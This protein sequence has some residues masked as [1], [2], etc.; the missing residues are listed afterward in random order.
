VGLYTVPYLEAGDYTV[1]VTKTGFEKYTE[2]NLHLDPAQTVKIDVKLT[3]GAAS[4]QV[5]VSASTLQINTQDATL[6]GLTTA[7]VI[8]EIPN[9][10]NNPFQYA[11][12]QNGVVPGSGTQSTTS[13][14]GSFGVGVNGRATFADFQIN[15]AQQGENNIMIDG[16]PTM[17]GGYNDPTVIPNLEGI[18]SVQILANAYSSEYGR[19]AGQMSITTKSGSNKFHGLA[20]YENRNEALMANTDSNKLNLILTPTNPAYRRAAFKVNDVGGEIDGPILKNRLFFTGSLHYL[21]HN[22]GTGESLHVP[23]LLERTGDW[24]STYVAGSNGQPTPVYLFNPSSVTPVSGATNVYQRPEFPHSSNCNNL[25]ADTTSSGNPGSPAGAQG[26][27]C[28]DMIPSPNP[29]GLYI[30]SL[31]P[32]P[33]AG[34]F[35]GPNTGNDPYEDNN[36]TDTIVNTLSQYTNE[37]RVDY[38]RGRHSIYGSGGIQWD[39]LVN[40]NPLGP[41]VV[42]GINDI[43]LVT[44]DRNYFVQIGDTV[45]FSPTL[46]V[47]ARYGFTRDHTASLGGNVSGFSNYSALGVSAA[48]QAIMIEPGAVPY[49]TPGNPW[50]SLTNYS[51]FNNKQEHQINHSGNASLTK[52]KGNWTFKAGGQFQIILENFNDFE[53]AAA[54]LG[55]CCANDPGGANGADNYSFQYTNAT[56][57][58]VGGTPYDV[59]PQQ[60]GAAGTLT[61]LGQGEWF[62]RPGANLRPAYAAKYFAFY[63]QNDWKVNRKLTLN[64]GARWE[65]QPGI[66][67]RYNRLAGY[68]FSKPNPLDAGVTGIVDF[69][70]TQ[71]YSRNLYDTE[72]NN[73]TPHVGFAYQVMQNLVA[74][75][76]FSINYLPDNTGYY[77]SPNDL[78]ESTWTSGN[79]GAQTYGA[80]PDGVPVEH[81]TD[82]APAVL[83]TGSNPLAPQTYGVGEAYFPRNYQNAYQDQFNFTIETSF[84]SKSQWLFSTG[85]A[86]T[87]QSHLFTRNLNFENIQSVSASAPGTLAAWRATLISTNGGTN[88]QTVQVA[89]PYQPT[90]GPLLPLQGSLAAA[91]VQ[92]YIPYLP[93]PL[94]YGGQQDG[95]LGFGSY[96]SL[97]THFAHRTSALYLDANFTWSKNLGFANSI[98]GGG[99]ISSLDLLCNRCN[100]NYFPQDT[101]FRV[102]VTS[103]Y[104]SPFSQGQMWAG[105]DRVVRAILGGWSISPVFLYT[106]GTPITLTAGS[107]Q[108]TARVNYNVAKGDVPLRLPSSFVNR[109]R[110]MNSTTKLTLPC[111]IVVTGGLFN[112][113]KYNPCAFSGPTVTTPNGNIIAD[114]YWYGNGNQTNGNIRGP[115]RVNVDTSIRRTFNLTERFKLDLTAAVTNLM[116]TAEWN[117][118]PSGGAGGTDTVNNP[119]NGQIVGLTTGG[120]YGQWGAGT[121]DP[122]QVELIGRIVF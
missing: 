47:D 8:D 30:L 106:D 71:G 50:E 64:L 39:T 100:R 69:P 13:A 63:S 67:E 115:L 23:S 59:Y 57:G 65:L 96:D 36:Y 55:G 52:L 68:D 87:R 101:P 77:S 111:G 42:K 11:Q 121:Y 92:Q 113:M 110:F 89:N 37:E 98:V 26:R 60:S 6:S 91:T 10:T 58:S 27:T 48:T 79:T 75:G 12:L 18:Q 66:T 70:G 41:G 44:F 104:Q 84:G 95:S 107:G 94:L 93:Y 25:Y 119:A 120:S 35:A 86:G 15:G 34:S 90:S 97:Q 46:V 20:S 99:N 9:V 1:T 76:G 82:T 80:T 31:Y 49:I 3:V 109:S 105:S 73:W 16:L 4:A 2:T 28:G 14:T 88:P 54:N 43:G 122:R 62:V 7:A 103:I 22:F 17:G 118:A 61:L 40:P 72:Y 117:S 33:N 74:R 102:V 5:E 78:G 83:A 29:I 114:E 21:T 81:L 108:F 56:G 53:E 32:K 116:N 112:K 85:Y 19:G 38:K 45:V 51:Q 24:G